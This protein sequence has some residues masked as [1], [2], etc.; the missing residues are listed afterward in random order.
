MKV[1]KIVIVGGG[2]A[3]WMTAAHLVRSFP[4]KDI[5]LIES[6]DI[7]TVGVGES[8]I[9]QI[10]RWVRYI[11]IDEK[12]FI[13]FTDAT[14]K[15]NIRFTD[16]YRKDAGYFDYPFGGPI[17]EESS[18]NPILDWH[19]IKHFYPSLPNTSMVDY[20][21]P[22]AQLW[23]NNKLSY[24]E[25]G[26]FGNFNFDSAVAY[27]FDATK[28]GLWLK[29]RYCIP[30]GVKLISSTVE[31]IE[32]SEENGIEFLV[33]SDKKKVYAD[34][35]IDC[36]GFKSLLLKEA[37]QEPFVSLEEML[38]N[39][40]AWAAQVPYVDRSK[41][42]EAFTNCTAI[43]N[44]WCWNIP[45]WTR[46]GTGYVYSDKFVSP[47]E[48]KEQFKKYLM[49]EKMV[50]PRTQE[51]VN[52]LTF[53]DISIRTG[54]HERIFV[55]NVVGIGLA[56]GFI[57]PL[58]SNG[59][60]TVHEFLFHL[61]DIL[62]RGRINQ[63]DRDLFNVH[64][65]DIFNGFAKFV[66]HH[67]SLSHRDDTEYWRAIQN[68]SFSDG[69]GDPYAPYETKS[70]SFYTT[71]KRFFSQWGDSRDISMSGMT[72]IGTGMNMFF[73]NDAR[74]KELEFFFGEGSLSNKANYLKKEWDL[75]KYSWQEAAKNA[76]SHEDFL[77]ENYHN[78]K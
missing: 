63:F 68:R 9:G 75:R 69:Y 43:E 39:N 48:A 49:S 38:P 51:Q 18:E 36:T 54:I 15:T 12:E 47:E 20:L 17:I 28:F 10:K 37:L 67:Y 53:K 2:S 6:P 31:D 74:V 14:F 3:G 24:N 40:R 41:E 30:R 55:K 65:K 26:Q 19:S 42:L 4:E 16:F 78:N 11:G 21:F 5:V 71:S 61:S 52:S 76:L 13:P 44:G 22:A 62:Q 73:I 56:A 70:S 23:Q 46:L 25:D 66:A 59:L 72:Y 45:L 35:F 8:T 50:I 7:P 29:E 60:Y 57:E 33:L 77:R 64:I 1:D 32:V 34:L 58:E 27:H